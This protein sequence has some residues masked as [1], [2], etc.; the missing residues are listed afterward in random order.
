MVVP[1]YLGARGG[2]WRRR[3]WQPAISIASDT[4]L[5]IVRVQHAELDCGP[6]T[7]NDPRRPPPGIARPRPPNRRLMGSATGRELKAIAKLRYIRLPVSRQIIGDLVIPGPFHVQ[8]CAVYVGML[9]GLSET[10]GGQPG[11]VRL[12][13]NPCRGAWRPCHI[14]RQAQHEFRVK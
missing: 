12:R 13:S 6:C 14:L 8:D 4:V 3:R 11:A 1:G 2:R 9:V 10:R 5:A 7:R